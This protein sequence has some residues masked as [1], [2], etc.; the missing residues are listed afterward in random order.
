MT[1]ALDVFLERAETD[2]LMF[3]LRLIHIAGIRQRRLLGA[4][5]PPPSVVEPS[6]PPALAVFCLELG[7]ELVRRG[8]RPALCPLCLGTIGALEHVG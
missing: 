7:G 4:W 1:R 6:F 8:E 2:E 3:A 5:S